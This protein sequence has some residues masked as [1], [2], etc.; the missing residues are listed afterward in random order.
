MPEATAV[1]C[2]IFMA[3]VMSSQFKSGSFIFAISSNFSMVM[4]PMMSVPALPEPFCLFTALWRSA[5]V[6]GVFSS[7]LKLLS[8]MTWTM[9]GQ[10]WPTL[11]AVKALYSFTNMAMFKPKA[12]M[13]GPTGGAGVA[14][15]PVIL[16]NFTCATSVTARTEV[17]LLVLSCLP[18]E[19]PSARAALPTTSPKPRAPLLSFRR[20]AR[21][22]NAGVA[23]VGAA[24]LARKAL[25]PKE[26]RAVAA[27]RTAIHDIAGARHSL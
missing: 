8:L 6:S 25:C 21:P 27:A 11:S 18:T 20:L 7:I 13:A 12:P 3:R 9:Q 10:V 17:A 16:D 24:V 1:P 5:A 22:R 15:P 26:Q 2:T 23:G 19:T 14:F 4:L